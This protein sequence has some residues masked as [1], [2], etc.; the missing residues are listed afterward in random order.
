MSL[1]SVQD[2]R[3]SIEQS[4]L[5]N[6]QSLRATQLTILVSIYVPLSFVTGVFGMNLKQFNGSGLSL[7]VCFVG[8]VIATIVTAI[9]FL[10]VQVHS[11]QKGSRSDGKKANNIDIPVRRARAI[12]NVYSPNF[13]NERTIEKSKV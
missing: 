8:I 4:Q 3:M 6:Q 9:I 2:A 7:R 1:I 5:R 11:K 10:A 13:E 12:S